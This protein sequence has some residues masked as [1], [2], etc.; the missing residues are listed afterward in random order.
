MKTLRRRLIRQAPVCLRR[1][2]DRKAVGTVLPPS[3]GL[4]R[5]PARDPESFR[6]VHLWL[7]PVPA[8]VKG[9][10]ALGADRSV[11]NQEA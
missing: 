9:G 11:A 4:L 7:R 2:E 6:C 1:R 3:P 10:A 8:A 5:P